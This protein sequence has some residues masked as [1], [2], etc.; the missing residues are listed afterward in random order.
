M[1]ETRGGIGQTAPLAETSAALER[2]ELAVFPTETLYAVGC[3]ALDALALDRLLFVKGR[4]AGKPFLV[5]V[6]DRA[7]ADRLVASW[8]PAAER[9]AAA[10]WPGPLTLLL[11]ARAGVHPALVAAGRIGIRLPPEGTIREL[12]RAVGRPLAAP[13]ANPAG[14]PPAQDIVEA[15]AFFG[16]RVASY[17]DGGPLGGAPS[18]IVDPGP[19]LE[20]IRVGAIPEARLRAL[21]HDAQIP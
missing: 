19:P 11:P 2:G 15:R 21:G 4:E 14:Q 1:T 9:L 8:S 3:D 13:S 5:L 12:L 10:F 7:M 17:L 6:A 16:N 20:I 18:T